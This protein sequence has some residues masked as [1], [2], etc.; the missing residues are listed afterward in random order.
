M[1]DRI[2]SILRHYGLSSSRLADMLG[3]QRSGISHILSGRNNPSYDFL[4]KLLEEF[5]EINA[6]W[7]LTGQGGML[8]K[9]LTDDSFSKNQMIADPAS[10]RHSV[11]GKDLFNATG[12]ESMVE[13]ED[14][15]VYNR[16]HPE[17]PNEKI[18]KLIILY[19]S[20]TFVEYVPGKKNAD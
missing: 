19:K 1:K 7:L 6:N 12:S 4:V 15:P 13:T 17:D 3:V 5:P 20:G 16:K 14:A 10:H 8:Q 11:P 2:S 9:Q 18:E